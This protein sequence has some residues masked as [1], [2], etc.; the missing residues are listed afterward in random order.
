[1]WILEQDEK[2]KILIFSTWHG[3]L[4]LI[5]N[6]LQENNILYKYPDGDQKRFQV[7]F[8][9][10][11]LFQKLSVLDYVFARSKSKLFCK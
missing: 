1:M 8:H 4:Q 11:M 2:D 7:R 3:A 6:G 5:K 10:R 9:F